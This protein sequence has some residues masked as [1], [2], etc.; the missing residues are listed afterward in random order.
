LPVPRF[1]QYDVA[2]ADPGAVLHPSRD[3]PHSILTVFT[4]DADVISPIVFCDN[5]EQLVVVR[6]PEI[7]APG[8]FAHTINKADARISD[9]R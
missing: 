7:P 6:H 3:S 5:C 4:P 2:L 1:D 8:F 9:W